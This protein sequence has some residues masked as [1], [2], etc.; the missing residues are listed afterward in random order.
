EVGVG[1]PI[2][3]EDDERIGS[4]KDIEGNFIKGDAFM[5]RDYWLHADYAVRVSDGS[6]HMSFPKRDLAAYKMNSP[7]LAVEEAE[8]LEP[9]EGAVI[10]ED[11][12]LQTR[13]NMERELAEQRRELP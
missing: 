3:S 5:S 12:Q 1:M 4:V 6:V 9:P 2:I 11:D 8:H 13:I 10:G 7:A